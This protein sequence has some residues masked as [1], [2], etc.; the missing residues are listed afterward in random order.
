[1]INK[2]SERKKNPACR[3]QGELGQAGLFLA[4]FQAVSIIKKNLSTVDQRVGVTMPK[5]RSAD[6]Y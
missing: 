3:A 6:F 2:F 5:H 4:A 1:V